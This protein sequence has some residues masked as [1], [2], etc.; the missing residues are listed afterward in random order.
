VEPVR[1]LDER[2]V[3][4]ELTL[5][6]GLLALGGAAAAGWAASIPADARNA[7]LLGFSAQRLAILAGLLFFALA[8]AAAGG[9]V[10]RR[11]QAAARRLNALLQHGV[12]LRL[13]LLALWAVGTLGWLGVFWPGERTPAL[14]A[15]L[16]RLRPALGLLLFAG[17][18]AMLY[19]LWAAGR[20]RWQSGRGAALAWG[21]VLGCVLLVWGL[22]SASGLGLWPGDAF[23]NKAGPPFTTLQ[24]FLGWLLGT[25]ALL[26]GGRK[27]VWL[28]V[29][30][31]LVLWGAAA[32]LWNRAALAPS[33]FNTQAYPPNYESYPFSDAQVYDRTAQYVLLGRGVTRSTDK[34]LYILFLTG[35][36]W[37]AGSAFAGVVTL[38]VVFL[39]ALPALVYLL[40][41]SL[42]SRGVGVMAGTLAVIKEM[43]AIASTNLL[44]VSHSR[45]ILTEVP[46]AVGLLVFTLLLVRWLKQPRPAGRPWLAAGGVL[47]LLALVRMN[48]LVLIPFAA[49]LAWLALGRRW[50]P[51]LLSAALLA[52]MAAASM[53]PWMARTQYTSGE[54]LRPIMGKVRGVLY[55]NR[56]TRFLAPADTPGAATPSATPSGEGDAL[57][58]APQEEEGVS[59]ERSMLAHYLHNLIGTL[60]MLPPS[61]AHTGLLQTIR[62]PY[63]ETTW[64]GVLLPGAGLALLLHLALISAG[65]ACA[66]RRW[67]WAGLAPLVVFLGYH[68]SN[69]VSLTS[70]GRYLVPVDW[71]LYL[72]FAVGALELTAQAAGC[73]GLQPAW[74]VMTS[75]GVSAGPSLRRQ[76]LAAALAFGL[77]GA[78]LPLSEQ[79]FP[80]R[81][82]P[83]DAAQAPADLQQAGVTGA[84][85]QAFLA[86]PGAVVLS[87]RALYPRFMAA[88]EKDTGSVRSAFGERAYGR[89]AFVLIGT[90]T[91][92]VLLPLPASPASFPH[93]A[94]VIVI[95]C[96][97]EDRLDALMVVVHGPEQVVLKSTP[98]RP[99][100]CPVAP[101]VCDAAGKC[102]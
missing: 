99:L 63:W 46:A 87:G 68:L 56:Y 76:A 84:E 35:L 20:G 7:V 91:A 39:A 28:D 3:R 21:L 14:Q 15:Y 30:L 29:L 18:A 86:Q 24:L 22:V 98:P 8:A 27:G 16:E 52:A 23:W 75:P 71:A 13:V 4:R 26:L 42:H 95:G 49:A 51:A 81:Y 44:Q 89:L 79:L 60:V 40:G 69:A 53:L 93:T 100:T 70:G 38:Q 32:V 65:I 85:A 25:L 88:G 37:L 9:L 1:N 47:G 73:V 11:P 10:W 43:N 33:H 62:L 36:N 54:F 55:E 59:L 96:K 83:Q 72:Y 102:E 78:V 66:W 90:K 77:L 48:V 80:L 31:C 58:A 19:L 17:L 12:R 41:R 57:P 61:F 97:G 6:C 2:I 45:M 67:R 94:D 64:D 92:E 50:R 5:V 82:P 101:A 34:A 74:T